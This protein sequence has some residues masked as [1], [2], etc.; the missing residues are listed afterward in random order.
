MKINPEN[1]YKC[2][3]TLFSNGAKMYWQWNCDSAWLVFENKEK[4]VLKSCEE[5]N[6]YECGR[7]GLNY[8]KEYPNYLLFQYKW[9]SGCCT[10]PDI[11]FINKVNGSE[12]KRITNDLF[13]WGNIEEDYV[14]HFSDSTYTRLIYLDNNTDKEYILRFDKEQVNKS[15]AKN[16]VL[17]LA[18]LFKNFKKSGNDFTFDYKTSEGVIKK[19]KIEFK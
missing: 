6:V 3:T 17:Q 12:L 9:I 1:Q 19:M 10:P 4:V 18:D 2:D 7:T 13:V 15:A 16:P 5:S 8:L 11:I 14:L